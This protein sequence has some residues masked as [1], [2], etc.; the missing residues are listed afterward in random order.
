MKE[1]LD[2]PHVLLGFILNLELHWFTLRRFGPAE[3]ELSQD[4]GIGHWFN[5]NSFLKEPEWVSKTY[6]GIM[7]QQ[8]ETEGSRYAF[9]ELPLT[10]LQVI[11]YSLSVKWIL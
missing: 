9:G 11:P 4:Q 3:P 2:K 5:L 6:L 10:S 8:A 1:Y 7:L